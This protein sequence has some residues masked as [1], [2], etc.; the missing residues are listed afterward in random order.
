MSTSPTS[1]TTPYVLA[2]SVSSGGIPKRP[3]PE[4]YV[5]KDGFVGDGRNH[6]KHIRPDRAVSLFDLEIM[7]QLVH[8]GFPLEPGAAGENLTL[9]GLNVQGLSPGTLLQIGDALLELQQP[10]KPCYVLDAIDPRLKEAIVG[11]C[12]YMASVV[13]EGTIRPGDSIEIVSSHVHSPG[14]FIGGS[15]KR[16]SAESRVV[17]LA[18][19]SHSDALQELFHFR[20]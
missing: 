8:E 11:R 14:G 13:R 17:A 19:L 5:T 16:D 3:L 10:R 12:G 20:G 18:P 4:G 2:V 6:A 9:V 15:S 7:E 1:A